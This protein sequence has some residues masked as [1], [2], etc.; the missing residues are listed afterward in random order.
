MI[1]DH[2]SNRSLK[3]LAFKTRVSVRIGSGK[4]YCEVANSPVESTIGLQKHALLKDGQGMLFPFTPPRYTEFHMG[5]VA[6]P[7]DIVFIGADRKVAKI[8]AN[9][10][11][12]TKGHWGCNNTAFVV[13]A[14]GGWAANHSVTEGLMVELN[15]FEDEDKEGAATSDVLRTITEA[16]V[17]A[18]INRAIR[19]G[20]IPALDRFANLSDID[21]KVVAVHSLDSAKSLLSKYDENPGFYRV[22]ISRMIREASKHSQIKLDDVILPIQTGYECP[23]CKHPNC[24]LHGRSQKAAQ[25]IVLML[26]PELM[27]QLQLGMDPF[28]SMSPNVQSAF[29]RISKL[30]EA[31]VDD[32]KLASA[33]KEAQGSLDFWERDA[34]VR[35][36]HDSGFKRAIGLLKIAQEHG[37][38]TLTDRRNPGAVNHISPETKYSSNQIPADIPGVG[39]AADF[40]N[41]DQSTG[42]DQSNPQFLNEDGPGYRPGSKQAGGGIHP[43]DRVKVTQAVDGLQ[44]DDAGVAEEVQEGVILVRLDGGETRWI[45]DKVL[46]VE[47]SKDDILSDDK[48]KGKSSG[49][50]HGWGH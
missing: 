44:D 37:K 17:K 2:F 14:K 6:F 25:Q 49:G 12:G 29:E 3:I 38:V 34:L 31:N 15:P 45:S 21:K 46:S 1:E 41:W 8:V 24:D 28:Q 10:Q 9:I 26:T 50:W 11:P 43:G 42:Y 35:S 47:K 16:S 19:L 23:C 18:E 36:L 39:D 20:Q 33:W 30:L 7:I 4:L 40:S 32:S 22:I 13:E 48:E 5:K 27:Q